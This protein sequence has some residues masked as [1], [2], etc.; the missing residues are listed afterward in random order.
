MN[1]RILR[2]WSIHTKN[3]MSCSACSFVVVVLLLLLLVTCAPSLILATTITTMNPAPHTTSSQSQSPHLDVPPLSS[4]AVSPSSSSSKSTSQSQSFPSSSVVNPMLYM[5]KNIQVIV[6]GGGGGDGQQTPIHPR[7]LRIPSMSLAETTASIEAAS[8]SSVLTAEATAAATHQPTALSS[9][10]SLLSFRERRRSPNSRLV[11]PN[12]EVVASSTSHGDILARD[13]FPG[14][15]TNPPHYPNPWTDDKQPNLGPWPSMA[16]WRHQAPIQ[17]NPSW[18]SHRNYEFFPNHQDDSRSSSSSSSSSS[19]NSRSKSMGWFNQPITSVSSSIPNVVATSTSMT[20]PLK[21]YNDDIGAKTDTDEDHNGDDSDDN[22]D[23]DDDDVDAEDDDNH[24]EDDK[25]VI[26]GDMD[27]DIQ[28]TDKNHPSIANSHD[29]EDPDEEYMD[30]APG[31]DMAGDIK[32]RKNMRNFVDTMASDM[33]MEEPTTPRNIRNSFI[34]QHTQQQQLYNL[35]SLKDRRQHQV[36]SSIARHSLVSISS[37]SLMTTSPR[38]ITPMLSPS[39]SPATSSFALNKQTLSLSGSSIYSTNNH[40]S[41]P[42]MGVKGEGE[43]IAA[44]K[45]FDIS[46]ILKVNKIKSSVSK[47]PIRFVIES[48]EIPRGNSQSPKVNGDGRGVGVGRRRITTTTVITE[49]EEQNENHPPVSNSRPNLKQLRSRQQDQQL[50]ARNRRDSLRNNYN[51]HYQQALSTATSSYSFRNMQQQQQQQQQDH[52]QQHHQQYYHNRNPHRHYHHHQ[53]HNNLRHQHL[54]QK[55]QRRYCS[56]RDPAQLAFEAPTVFEGKI[57]SMTPDRRMNFSA[58]VEVREVF[59]QQ[60]G[61][62]LQKYLR[63]QFAYRN[64]SGE[65]DIYREQL[66][67]RGLVKGDTIEPGRIY[68]LFVQQIDIGNFTILG[69]PIRKTKRA[70]EAVRNAVSENYAQLASIRSI[71]ASNRTVENGQEL[72]IVCKVTGRPPPKVTWFKDH[73]SINRNRKLYQF[74]HYKKRSELIIRSFNTSDAGRYECRAKNKVNRNIERRTIVIKAYPIQRFDPN[75][76]GAGNTC[77]DDASEF[78][79]NGGTCKF[80]SEI[81]SYS[82]ICP[83]GFIGERCDRKEVNNPNFML[84]STAKYTPLII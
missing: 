13:S 17:Q 28:M 20:Q 62:R 70:I 45:V 77:P 12:V 66:R 84:Q 38:T 81:S 33:A 27:D 51:K 74:A 71:S 50:A 78:C 72:R 22:D 40:K 69:Q 82:C 60:I 37:S 18:L 30:M 7:N 26:Y 9:A 35:R 79:F 42:L 8:T 58:T 39:P 48:Y 53:Q 3:L 76:R 68:L 31:R 44:D 2:K 36:A 54:R 75:P 1:A 57:V 64:S 23:D 4:P 80:F 11:S 5:P 16:S 55:H 49:E 59:K 46:N 61:Y 15:Y 14:F 29:T 52:Q 10:T 34:A 43:A 63:L 65:C 6:V 56:A 47:A 24:N 83:E 73:R 67:P 21:S 19:S 25:D 41:M 32:S